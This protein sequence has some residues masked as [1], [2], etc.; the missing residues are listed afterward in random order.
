MY[1][2]EYLVFNEQIVGS[3]AAGCGVDLGNDEGGQ[4]TTEQR[5]KVID[6]V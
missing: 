5:L 3:V 1:A 2:E 6:N 4:K